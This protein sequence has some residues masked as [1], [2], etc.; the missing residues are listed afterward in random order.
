MGLA[1]LWTSLEA[2]LTTN[3][4][5]L[6]DWV[7]DEWS[8]DGWPIGRSTLLCTLVT[9]VLSLTGCWNLWTL[10]L[11]GSADWLT[12]TNAEP[13]AWCWRTSD[14]ICWSS[15]LRA[16]WSP[17]SA[18]TGAGVEE[19]VGGL[20]CCTR[21]NFFSIKAAFGGGILFTFVWDVTPSF[22]RRL[23]KSGLDRAT[24]AELLGGATEELSVEL[25][26]WVLKSTDCELG[27]GG[28]G[29]EFWDEFCCNDS[30]F[31][32]AWAACVMLVNG[33]GPWYGWAWAGDLEPKETVGG[34]AFRNGIGS[35]S[36][37]A[38]TFGLLKWAVDASKTWATDRIIEFALDAEFDSGSPFGIDSLL[39]PTTSLLPVLKTI[40]CASPPHRLAIRNDI[41]W[42]KTQK[43][44]H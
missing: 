2:E 3:G 35:P 36:V 31:C 43:I 1:L 30:L 18:G 33:K 26:L 9:K 11:V 6:R 10:W 37:G 42:K 13:V 25:D 28:G 14:G 8:T 19:G 4:M 29:N 15:F 20:T 38:T 24:L 7:S 39:F 21:C 17:A 27:Y 12:Q 22:N 32:M 40:S 34:D 23:T 41:T 44:F 16:V 5:E